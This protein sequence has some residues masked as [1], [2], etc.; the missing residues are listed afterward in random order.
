MNNNIHHKDLTKEIFTDYINKDGYIVVEGVIKIDLL[1]SV[2]QDLVISIEKESAFHGSNTYKDYGM[3]LCCPIYGGNFIHI[4]EHQ[5]LM[6]PFDWILGDTSIIYVY[7]SSSLPPLQKN[8][9]SRIHVDRPHFIE[10]YIEALGCLILLDDFTE[11]NGATWVLPQ[12][13]LRHEEPSEENFYQ[14]SIRI[15]APKGSVFYFH[16]RLW[17]AGGV[18][19]TEDWRHSLGIGMVRSHL[20]QRIDIPRAMAGIDTNKISNYGLQKLG[21][22]SQ[23]PSS[24]EEFHLPIE[25]RSFKQ[26]S[27]WDK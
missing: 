8:H 18:N 10:N 14:N 20:K 9:A 2:K 17:H 7:T 13:H 4:A 22:F 16:L 21:F 11:E 5:K 15:I 24:L 1:N 3:L 26:K 27:E 12:S 23:P 19:N 6:Q 25:K